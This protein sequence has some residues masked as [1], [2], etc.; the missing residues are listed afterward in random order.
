MGLFRD[1]MHAAWNVFLGKNETTE[2]NSYGQAVSYG[3]PLDRTRLSYSNERSIIASIYT[4][5]AIDASTADFN[6]VRVD[7]EGRFLEKIDSGLNQCLTVEANIDQGPLHIKM[8]AFMSMF[9]CGSIAV[10]PVETSLNP[11]VSAGYDIRNIRIGEIIS[12]MPYHVKVNLYNE[13]RGRR[14]EITL[15]KKFVAIAENPFYSVMNEPNSTL[16]RLI[17]KLN[18]L[19]VVDEQSSSGKM[20]IIIQLPYTIRSEARRT[21]AE[22]RRKDIEHQLKDSKYGIAYTDAAEKIVQLNR[23]T[24]NN[25]LKQV[26]YLTEMLYNEL[27]LTKEVMAGTADEAA[28][29]NYHSRTIIPLRTALLEAMIR[30]FLT[31]TARSQGQS[32]MAFEDPL[33]YV[34]MSVLAEI[35]DKFIRNTIASPNDFR[36]AI[37]WKPSKD[38]QA[39][40]LQNPNMPQPDAAAATAPGDVPVAAG[41]DEALQSAMGD[42][43]AMLD[44]IFAD[45]GVDSNVAA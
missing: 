27:G 15:E 21:A 17:R 10:V 45:L 1:M 7:E 29:L 25:L 30:V 12:W 6:H 34:P 33:K 41:D 20:D 18:L 11:N 24:E 38:P 8:D 4:R 22:Q 14:E 28:M 39:D 3:R 42:V 9:N 16:Q 19:D 31:K 44:G 43:N 32:I 23:P 13:K 2:T 36:Q 26:E 37:G 5:L 40:K 35:A